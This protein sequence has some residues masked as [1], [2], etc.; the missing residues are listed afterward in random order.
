MRPS[1]FEKVLEFNEQFGVTLHEN[2]VLDIFDKDPKL[3]EYRMNLIR[4]EKRELE[5]AVKT[6]DFKETVDALADILYVVYGMGASIGVDMDKAYD[7]VHESNMSKLCKNE[8]EAKA[9][10]D[11]YER[12]KETTGYDSPKYRKSFDGKYYVVYNESTKKILKSINYKEANFN[13]LF[14]I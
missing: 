14:H 13:S 9:T 4:E 8:D 12:N 11:W 6:K 5:E 1:N 7:I 10:V 2:P 3:V